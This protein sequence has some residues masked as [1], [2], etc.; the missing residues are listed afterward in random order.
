MLQYCFDK[1]MQNFRELWLFLSELNGILAWAIHEM[2]M[3]SDNQIHWYKLLTWLRLYSCTDDSKSWAL[4][5]PIPQNV[6]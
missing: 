1:S 5:N 6:K 3:L 2:Y 4:V